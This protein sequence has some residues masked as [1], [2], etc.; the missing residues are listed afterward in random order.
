[1]AAFH[2]GVFYPPSIIFFLPNTIFALN[3]FYILHFIILTVPIYFL[4]RSWKLSV[5]AACC[6]SLTAL[7][8]SFFLATTML[9]NWFLAVVWLPLIFLLFQKF[10]IEK[11]ARYL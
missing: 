9:S 4:A 8:S 2:T 1:M 10:I 3:L 6:S 5:P 11:K 7:L